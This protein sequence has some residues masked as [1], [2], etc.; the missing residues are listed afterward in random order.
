MNII[1]EEFLERRER[2]WPYIMKYINGANFGTQLDLEEQRIFHGKYHKV[3][4]NNPIT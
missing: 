2:S 3:Y 1:A 4:Y